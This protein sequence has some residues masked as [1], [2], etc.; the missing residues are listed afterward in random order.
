M[1]Q[2]QPMPISM[3]ISRRLVQVAARSLPAAHRERYRRELLA[4]LA[5][6]PRK[7]QSGFALRVLVRSLALRAA[8]H[9]PAAVTVADAATAAPV[10][11]FGCRMHLYHHWK[12]YRTDDGRRYLGVRQVRQG[13]RGDRR[14]DRLHRALRFLTEPPSRGRLPG[15]SSVWRGVDE[16]PADL[17]STVVT[18]GVF[19]GVHRGHRLI[20]ERA[21]AA[22]RSA[23]AARGGP[24]L[25]GGRGHL[26]PAPVGGRTGREPPGDALD[27]R[28]PGLAADRGR[29]RRSPRP[30]L[31]ARPW[32]G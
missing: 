9:A 16:V 10:R 12:T 5:E 11:P 6:V 3:R 25:A 30:A 20:L 23:G 28:P 14:H 21:L 13:Q 27:G 29:S 22:A 18:I 31:L 2:P 19:D 24:V 15:V 17:G 26:R 4:E 7:E 32:L 8:L 1:T